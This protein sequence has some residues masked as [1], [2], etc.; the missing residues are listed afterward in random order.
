MHEGYYWPRHRDAGIAPPA[1]FELDFTTRCWMC[2]AIRCHCG[3][4][5]VWIDDAFMCAYCVKRIDG[6]YA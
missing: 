5:G 6:A 4:G 2:Q 1:D 3:E